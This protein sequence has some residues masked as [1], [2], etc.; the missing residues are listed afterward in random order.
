MKHA[1]PRL[2]WPGMQDL[3]TLTLKKVVP[4][5]LL[6][7][8]SD[9]R[10]LKPCLLHGDCEVSNVFFVTFLDGFETSKVV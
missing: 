3:C 9:G 6:P 5:L 8:Q 7:L 2:N 1:L 10:I 4:R